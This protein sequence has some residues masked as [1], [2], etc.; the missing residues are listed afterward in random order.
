MDQLHVP[1]FPQGIHQRVHAKE[2][3]QRMQISQ[4]HARETLGLLQCGQVAR[5]QFSGL[6]FQ[7]LKTATPVS[8]QASKIAQVV[9]VLLARVP[10]FFHSS[11][12]RFSTSHLGKWP[13]I[14]PRP[15]GLSS[16][17]Y[18][19]KA[20]LVSKAMRHLLLGFCC[21]TYSNQSVS[22]THYS[23]L[24]RSASSVTTSG[25]SKIQPFCEG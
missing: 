7:I 22:P 15:T 25:W 16:I 20:T 17:G 4:T 14:L 3:I 19:W 10:V 24:S 8:R 1:V 9:G 18:R 6:S 12:P 2:I 11:R 23:T 13:A 5:G 21:L